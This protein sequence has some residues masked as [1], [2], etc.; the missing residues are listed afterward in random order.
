M[1]AIAAVFGRVHAENAA[2]T[3]RLLDH[4][5]HR[6]DQ[7]TPMAIT[8]LWGSYFSRVEGRAMKRPFRRGMFNGIQL[9]VGPAVP[10]AEATPERLHDLV[11]ALRGPEP[12]VD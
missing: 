5:R 1:T 10:P 6:G 12:G 4:M 9:S 8:G 7:T 3:R 2:A 11:A